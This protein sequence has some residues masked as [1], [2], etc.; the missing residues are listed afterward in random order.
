MTEEAAETT[1]AAA[2]TET[3]AETTD[4]AA[5]TTDAADEQ[6]AEQVTTDDISNGVSMAAL[7]SGEAADENDAD[8]ASGEG[9]SL[10]G[11]AHAYLNIDT[12]AVD[13]AK[14]A[15]AAEA[16]DEAS[17]A[18]DETADK[19][20]DEA[21]KTDET[22]DEADETAT[23]SGSPKKA[24]STGSPLRDAAYAY[25]DIDGEQVELKNAELDEEKREIEQILTET[26]AYFQTAE[27][28]EG[29]AHFAKGE[30]EKAVT[31]RP[32]DNDEPSGTRLFLFALMGVREGQRGRIAPDAN[33]YVSL[34]DDEEREAPRYEL[35]RKNITLT[36]DNPDATVTVRRTAGLKDF[37]LAYLSTVEP[38]S[39]AAPKYE[40][41]QFNGR[42]VQFLPGETEKQIPIKA[43]YFDKSGKFGLRLEAAD[44]DAVFGNYYM[45]VTIKATETD[46]EL[47]AVPDEASLQSGD[48]E[49][50]LMAPTVTQGPI[51]SQTNA[52]YGMK[53][54]EIWPSEWSAAYIGSDSDN[55]AYVGSNGHG[56]YVGQ[57]DGGK[58]SY[59]YTKKP[60][61]MTGVYQ[62]RFHSQVHDDNYKDKDFHTIFETDTDQS[63]DG[64]INHTA[65]SGP[66]SVRYT[67]LDVANQ[68][69]ALYLKWGVRADSGDGNNPEGWMDQVVFYHTFYKFNAMTSPTEFTRDVYDY[70]ELNGGKPQTYHTYWDNPNVQAYTPG[71]N[72]NGTTGFYTSTTGTVYITPD[73]Q[74][75][76]NGLTLAGVWLCRENNW[77]NQNPS[78]N[79]YYIPASNGT[80]SFQ[81]TPDFVRK[82]ISANVVNSTNK[83]EENIYVYPKYERKLVTVTFEN[84]DAKFNNRGGHVYDANNQASHFRNIIEVWQK[85]G[86]KTSEAAEGI[87]WKTSDS[88]NNDV[89]RVKLPYLSVIRLKVDEDASAVP[90][91]VRYRTSYNGGVT[92]TYHKKGEK[93]YSSAQGNTTITADDVTMADIPLNSDE[94]I[95][96]PNTNEQTFYIGYSPKSYSLFKKTILKEMGV[97]DLTGV[98]R[99]GNITDNDASSQQ[100]SGADGSMWVSGARTDEAY[101]VTATSPDGYYT[102]WG[103]LSGDT[104]N[105]GKI[106]KSG[107]TDAY[108]PRSDA[109]KSHNPQYVYGDVLNVKLDIDNMRYYYKF[110]KTLLYDEDEM[111]PK[112]GYVKRQKNTFLRLAN[113]EGPMGEPEPVSGANV[114]V[115]GVYG[116]T[117]RD[118]RYSV[119]IPVIEDW[120]ALSLAVSADGSNYYGQVFIEDKDGETILPAFEQ[121]GVKSATIAYKNSPT[122][123][124][125]KK[126]SVTAAIEDDIMTI[127][128]QVTTDNSIRPV[129]ARF[130]VYDKNGK[131]RVDCSQDTE[132]YKTSFDAGSNTAKLVLNPKFHMQ[133]KDTIWVQFQGNSGKWYAPIDMGYRFTSAVELN[134]FS[135]ESLGSTTMEGSETSGET[136]NLIGSPL[137]ELGLGLLKGLNSSEHKSTST[138]EPEGLSDEEKEEYVHYLTE[139]KFGFAPQI[140]VESKWKNGQKVEDEE[141]DLP[142]IKEDEDKDKIH[143]L[144]D[145]WKAMNGK[146]LPSMDE[147]EGGGYATESKFSW[148]VKPQIGFKLT[149]AT[150]GESSTVYVEDVLLFLAVDAGIGAEYA[151]GLPL[152]FQLIV[153]LNLSGRIA[154]VYNMYNEYDKADLTM[155][156]SMSEFHQDD[157]GLYGAPKTI[158]NHTR[159]EGYVFFDLNLRLDLGIK[160]TIFYVGGYAAFGFDFDFKFDHE[161]NHAYGQFNYEFGVVVEVLGFEVWSENTDFDGL[162]IFSHDADE[163]FDFDYEGELESAQLKALQKLSEGGDYA[164]DR[165]V[166]RSYLQN[167]TAWHGKPTAWENFVSL[168]SAA[169]DGN[170]ETELQ[171]G[172]A[173]N[174][175]MSLTKIS[176]D[177]L[178]M[179]FVGDVPTRTAENSRAVFYA[180]GDGK[181]WGDPQILDDDGTVDDYPNVCD[182]GDGRLL[183]TWSS[184]DKVLPEGATLEDSLKNLDLKAAFFDKSS[185][186]FGEAVQLTHTTDEDYCADVMPHAAYDAESGRLLLTYTKTEY[187]NLA[188][189]ENLGKAV[190]V[191]AYL[192]YE[193]GAWQNSG[194]AYGAEELDVIA[195]GQ[196][197][198]EAYKA[199]YKEQ[200]YGQRFLDVRI[201]RSEGADLLR[202]I[203]SDAISYNNLALNAWTIDW[204]GSLQT[205]TD[206]DVFLQIYN[207][208]ERTF[209]HI[210]R[211]TEKTGQ[212]ALPRFARSDNA[213]YLFYGAQ[214]FD[215]ETGE[216][217]ENGEIRY[218]NVSDAIRNE[219]YTLNETANS[220][221]Y[222]LKYRTQERTVEGPEGDSTIPAEDV[223]YPAN[224]AAQCDNITDYT[225]FVDNGGQ[226]YLFFSDS[227]DAAQS[228]LIRASMYLG[229]EAD[230]SASSGEVYDWS[231]PVYL[232]D[233]ESV[234]YSGIGGVAL[235][236]VIYLASGKSNYNDKADTSLVLVRHTP[237]A[238]M[239]ID[240]VDAADA[241]PLPSGQTALTAVVRNVGLLAWTEPFEV[242]FDVTAKDGKGKVLGTT[243]VT[244]QHEGAV[245]GGAEAD[246]TAY[247]DIPEEFDSLTF[248]ASYNGKSVEC[249]RESGA[250]LSISEEDIGVRLTEAGDRQQ[251]AAAT[252]TNNGNKTSGLIAVSAYT[253]ADGYLNG[254]VLPSLAPGESESFDITLEISDSAYE[255]DENGLG[256]AEIRVRVD[257]LE[258]DSVQLLAADEELTDPSQISKASGSD[259]T[260]FNGTAQKLF[261]AEAVRLLKDVTV[262]AN[263]TFTVREDEDGPL[264]PTL[265]GANGEQLR[266][267]WLSTSDPSV[268]TIDATNAILPHTAGAATLTGIVTPKRTNFVYEADGT[269]SRQDWRDV[270]P[271]ELQKTVTAEVTV[272]AAETPEEPEPAPEGSYNVVFDS[273]GGTKVP[274]EVVKDGETVTEPEAPTREGYEFI[275]W[276]L[277][278]ADYDFAE[279]VTDNIT[280]TAN[281][282]KSEADANPDNTNTGKKGCYVATSVYG[283]YD[284]P[285]VW[286]L[287]R[288]RDETLA[289]TWYGRL[290]I[291]AYY[292]VSPTAVKWFGDCQWFKDFFRD[293]LDKLVSNLQA[294]GFEST[295]YDDTDW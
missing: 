221:Y 132:H 230:E 251:Y 241:Y 48:D 231:I 52:P 284:C 159:H 95:V 151:V 162:E 187:D 35:V 181:T 8:D 259:V 191:I 91:G 13:E 282:K 239:T 243:Q 109:G 204:D 145:L 66:Y 15:A 250:F 169:P 240:S 182:L 174:P 225:V 257:E 289:A 188:K 212:H 179:V 254:V 184:G 58:Y 96:T 89:F 160:W 124:S 107:K 20:T 260:S 292:A 63:W 98:A 149:L 165:T 161:G 62:L 72:L 27:G 113:N 129:A 153:K 131:L 263:I 104:N 88:G 274:Y 121:F 19:A 218:L 197:D 214:D 93:K 25:L 12:E 67:Y 242:T 65:I 172:A 140:E 283:S 264:Q 5:P 55:Y 11:A 82:L 50:A 92:V 142:F 18:S 101:T 135:L 278:G 164:I 269:A 236:G 37:T 287:R 258:E 46:G 125:G 150:R 154:G 222:E 173:N 143:D 114:S 136:F 270:I 224:V 23:L 271:E 196:T 1:D 215:D 253:S 199:Y 185:K 291:R 158:V 190:S 34:I 29:I 228:R 148:S 245:I 42:S 198:P 116:L 105:D 186:T 4:E 237:F 120:G 22:A 110:V 10:R 180:I 194:D 87:I 267:D 195:N 276:R 146:G 51:G 293:R 115:A 39:G 213:T 281:W 64:D 111:E 45:D 144:Q 200:W 106:D 133:A 47:Q 32:I 202:V 252:V 206:R 232:T 157:M 256:L 73:P 211:V 94:V 43:L 178:L 175:Q 248:T 272:L 137:G 141:D 38:T 163:P 118:G 205:T 227:N 210:I 90:N 286:T 285:E 156:T 265:G 127:T 189:Q 117:D 75:T 123:I 275:G 108:T 233:G 112:T 81:N 128:A 244:A 139:F 209:T 40:Y 249:E 28:A 255:I 208:T 193:N 279:L 126:S 203:D 2:T 53:H 266:V 26:N 61:D 219:R 134:N 76:A 68:N 201:D 138:Y 177:E 9:S 234:C 223:W 216:L 60:Y 167:R 31:I 3:P 280:L 155:S 69:R 103:N 21:S 102:S 57:F 226:M 78:K 24:Y 262:P 79:C 122:S 268:L 97:P 14:A 44:E 130:F 229:N 74:A 80:V 295:P 41:Q 16:T 56:V 220:S 54:N 59:G 99:V 166:D 246:V 176:D 235:D 168:F 100:T 294:D 71:L 33:T 238:E 86:S 119:Q 6:T 36:E 288:F 273:A 217:K 247:V 30:T 152:G 170:G 17:E 147:P 77:N 261:D 7:E 49:A 83:E 290:F 85:G 171:R 70:S 84:K 207:F 277:D 192:F 183:V